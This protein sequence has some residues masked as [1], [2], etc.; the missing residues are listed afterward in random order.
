MRDTPDPAGAWPWV[1]RRWAFATHGID[2]ALAALLLVVSLHAAVTAVEIGRGPAELFPAFGAAALAGI[3]AAALLALVRGRPL[4]DVRAV[5]ACVA[6]AA[7]FAFFAGDVSATATVAEAGRPPELRSVYLAATAA[8]SFVL[9]WVVP[10]RPVEGLLV[11]AMVFAA[12]WTRVLLRWAPDGFDVAPVALALAAAIHARTADVE[13]FRAPPLARPALLFVAWIVVSALFSSSQQTSLPAAGRTAVQGL[14]FVTAA[15]VVLRGG[16]GRGLLYAFAAIATAVSCTELANVALYARWAGLESALLSRP[17]SFGIHPNLVAPYA[18]IGA[19]AC[20]GAL[21]CAR[22]WPGRFAAAA[23]FGAGAVSVH[24]HRSGGATAALVA[25]ATAALLGGAAARLREG[26]ATRLAAT[27]LGLGVAVLPVVLF[28]GAVATSLGASRMEGGGESG[29]INVGT[30]VE[31]WNAAR[32]AMAAHPVVGLGPRNVEPHAEW[33]E[34]SIEANVDWSNHPHDLFLELGETLGIP[35]LAAFALLVAAAGL[36]A[37]RAMLRRAGADAGLAAAATAMLAAYLVD[38]LF[39]RGFAE[40]AVVSDSFW[41]A[42]LLIAAA[43]AR[44]AEGA[45]VVPTGAPT[46]AVR[47]SL[48]V[49][50]TAALVAGGAIPLACTAL[51][52][53]IRWIDSWHELRT[54]YDS[55]LDAPGRRGRLEWALAIAPARADL[56]LT[57]AEAAASDAGAR[58]RDH[59][60]RAVGDAPHNA[61]VLQRAAASYLDGPIPASERDPRRALELFQRA[62]RLGAPDERAHAH[63]GAA[64][65]LGILGRADEA[66]VALGEALALAPRMPISVHGFGR[67]KPSGPEGAPDVGFHVSPALSLSVPQ[68]LQR[69]IARHRGDLDTSFDAAWGSFARVAECYGTILRIDEAV[70]LL[71]ELERRAPT[72]RMNIPALRAQLRMA[73][74][75]NEEALADLDRTEAAGGWTPMGSIF[76]SRALESLGRFSESRREVERIDGAPM[77]LA[78]WTALA[79]DGFRRRALGAMERSDHRAAARHWDLAAR[80][81]GTAPDRLDLACEA[82][83]AE[84]RSFLETGDDSDLGRVRARM[85]AA[86]RVAGGLTWAELDPARLE[87]AGASLARTAGPRAERVFDLVRESLPADFHAGSILLVVGMGQKILD[88]AR[89][90]GTAPED[91]IVAITDSLRRIAESLMPRLHPVVR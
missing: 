2:S 25:G 20:M 61:A 45:G 70:A 57:Y 6:G 50:A 54:K 91:R 62:A 58:T 3:A 72:P 83:G 82:A 5:V 73:A 40:F 44:E 90:N 86:F 64:R 63:L 7:S 41:F 89:A 29:R 12:P 39:D 80:C 49:A 38:G 4:P 84:L 52:Q 55:L 16:T 53:S 14:A 10:V 48:S 59:V 42:L 77:D 19:T 37:R 8:L 21:L 35:G 66:L 65:S 9:G 24:L 30:R 31:F 23:G 15:E 56:R 28:A 46:I 51:E 88:A 27:A 85:G 36:R 18:A 81:A 87:Q 60:E 32:R 79:L 1:D 71:D 13:P 68:A 22:T 17:S 34:E 76:R 78:G 26:R 69:W 43:G 33:V 67:P 11:A 47:L 75:R 74:G